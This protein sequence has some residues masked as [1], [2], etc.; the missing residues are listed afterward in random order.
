MVP[1]IRLPFPG[2]EMAV[3]AY[4]LF[5]V[6]AFLTGAILAGIML[7]RLRVKFFHASLLLFSMAV[8]FLIGARLWNA[9]VN[10]EAYG[11]GAG[12]FRLRI[13]SFRFA[14]FSLLGGITGAFA[15]LL[16][17]SALFRHSAF[18]LLDA[19]VIPSGVA[20]ALARIGC[21][22]NG[23]CGGKV[24]QSI[25][26]I[27]FPKGGSFGVLPESFLPLVGT[28]E[29]LSYPTQL[30]EMSLA[31]MGLLLIA[32]FGRSKRKI[33]GGME[34]VR[35]WQVFRIPGIPFLFYGVWTCIM[36]WVVLPF[37]EL[38]YPNSVIAVLYPSVYAFLIICLVSLAIVRVH[39]AAR[40]GIAIG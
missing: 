15:A 10:P 6:I 25:L 38:P 19:F 7:R 27:A 35:L 18:V 23:C 36:R 1:V 33:R 30:F 32:L 9:V 34:L 16:A 17:Y 26:G 37:R 28:I 29:V 13:W 11:T 21:F 5:A 8:L 4:T 14:C 12:L 24:T 3:H 39:H 20:F 22:L 31:L 2:H 40:G